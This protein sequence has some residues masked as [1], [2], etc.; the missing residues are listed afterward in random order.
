MREPTCLLV[1][2]FGDIE[3]CDYFRSIIMEI[4]DQFL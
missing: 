4:T 2:V 1:T 3:F